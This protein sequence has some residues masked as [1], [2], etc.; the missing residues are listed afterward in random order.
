MIGIKNKIAQI[1][2]TKKIKETWQ[3]LTILKNISDDDLKHICGTDGALYCILLRYFA[4]LFGILTVV[5]LV[6]IIP[7]YMSGYPS[8]EDSQQQLGDL[9]SYLY[10]VTI[11]NVSAKEGKV[12]SSFSMMV[13][14]SSTL[15]FTMVYFYLK[16]SGQWKYKKH[17]HF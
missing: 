17:T 9:Y 5:N 16:K 2:S 7:V 10:V 8:E 12:A 13:I 15:T 11:L 4:I 6:F 1:L 14:L 3:W